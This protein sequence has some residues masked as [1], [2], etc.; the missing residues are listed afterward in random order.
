MAE[1]AGFLKDGWGYDLATGKPVDLRKPEEEVR[2]KYE[3]ILH[4]DYGYDYKQLNIEVF[5][6]RGSRIEKNIKGIEI[7][8]DRADIV[9]YSSADTNKRDQYQDII[10]IVETKRPEQSEGVK[11]LMSYVS[12]SSAR[13]GVWTNGDRGG[14]EYIY[15]DSKTG[16]IKRDFIFDIPKNGETVEDMGL[17]TKQRLIPA[18]DLKLI[19]RRLLKTLYANT[20]ISRREKLGSEMI[21]LIFAKIWDERYD[22]DKVP[23][24]RVSIEDTPEVVTE[25]I[26]KLFNEVKNELVRDG[27]FEENEKITLDPKSLA[28][29]VGQ[30]QRYSL[31]LS[32]DA[33]GDAFEVF[34]ESKFVGEKG[35]FFTPAEII[36]TAID[37]VNPQPQQ[38]IIDP[39]CGSGRFLIYALEHVWKI[40]EN[41]KRFKGSPDLEKLKQEAAEKYY[42]GI[43]KEI[44]LVKIAKAYM[45]IVGDG[46]G[47]IVHENTLHQAGDYLERA[48]DLF[49]DIKDGKPVF[50]Q[51]SIVMT[52]PPFGANIKVLKDEASYFQLGH[53]WKKDEDGNWQPLPK[54]KATA[55][56]ILFVER[57][58]DMLKDGGILAIILPETIF[59]AVN[60]RYVLNYIK[61]G[62]NIKA[63]VDLAHN[64]FR[65][66]NNA[67]T[68]L[69]ILQKGKP[70]QAN[71]IMAV[72]EETG[73]DHQ[74]RQLYRFDYQT[75]K[76]TT[77][78]WDDTII[79]RKELKNPYDK[80]N[81][82]VFTVKPEE[83]KGDVY[84]P[85]YYWQKRAQSILEETKSS[86]YEPIR[87]Q[88]LLDEKIIVAYKGYGSPPSGFKG[89]G[90]IPYIRVADIISWELYK[91]PTAS[92][93]REVYLKVK[94]NGVDLLPEDV[95]FVRR[96]SYRIGS[97][98]MVS[99]FDTEVLLTGELVIMRVVNPDNEY[100][101]NPY[102]LIYLLSHHLT[103]RQLPQKVLVDTTLPNIANRWKELYLP[104][105]KDKAE[106]I[107][108]TERIKSTF[109]SKWKAQEEISKLRAEFG[110]ITT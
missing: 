96:G 21:R 28:W 38:S 90:E 87:I 45:A 107:T 68:L 22:V 66:Y 2:Q 62:N 29:V 79:I 39:A 93:P 108:M 49:V 71:I 11:Q 64:T 99:P 80:N 85:R 14:I 65:P 8:R 23:K 53:V 41:D 51:F 57:C 12:A 1:Q 18:T 100:H 75:K 19:F 76:F 70:Q 110:S 105:I 43:D 35:E 77:N 7:E 63:I 10:G 78:I 30:L 5:I 67:K 4:N 59:H 61:R 73:H 3:L 34:A 104:T 86:G 6:K 27:V 55:P 47:G 46:R 16:S 13:W 31:Y 92:V 101:I 84:V 97:V 72:A 9:I 89:R 56:Q 60:S 81:Q 17:I 44:D 26:Q 82:Y 74:G 106:I 52:N 50:R 48:H 103:Q 32:K 83:I 20:N 88:K 98:A 37:L 91:N 25:R 94:G 36:N 33:V 109:V 15:H 54:T 58:L 69:L 40:M 102:Y 42:Y 95:I 24:F